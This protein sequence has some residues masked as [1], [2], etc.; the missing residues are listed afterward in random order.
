VV[1]DVEDNISGGQYFLRPAGEVLL[2][3]RVYGQTRGKYS[4][5]LSDR[6]YRKQSRNESRLSALS[7]KVYTYHS[8]WYY[9]K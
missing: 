9:L 2:L 4:I 8:I 6:K 3:P 7:V 1:N 5:E